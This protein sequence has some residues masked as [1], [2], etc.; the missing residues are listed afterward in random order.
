MPKRLRIL[1]YQYC[2]SISPAQIMILGG[3]SCNQNVRDLRLYNTETK[4]IDDF[5]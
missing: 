2:L 4:S 1:P 5:A 3:R